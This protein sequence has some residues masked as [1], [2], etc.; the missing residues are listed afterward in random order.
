MLDIK[1]FAVFESENSFDFKGFLLK[2]A[3]Y[4]KW[5][6]ICLAITFFIAYQVNLRKQKVYNLTS[7]IA[8]KEQDNPLFTNN[9]SL[10]FNW[11]GASDQVQN[12]ASTLQSRSHNEL[13]VNK[14]NFF[15]NYLKDQKYYTEDVYGKTPF[16]I[17]LDK[18]KNQ[19]YQTPFKIIFTGTNTFKIVIETEAQSL[20]VFNYNTGQSATVPFNANQLKKNYKFGELIQLPFLNAIVVKANFPDNFV[21]EE[22]KVVFNAIDG[23]VAKYQGI[24]VEVDEK[25]S[26]V[27]RLSFTDSNKQRI[28]DFL[29]ETVNVLIQRQLDSKNLFADN[30]ISFIDTTLKRMEGEMETNNKELKDF[31]R[32]K[33]IVEL[34]SGGTELQS[35]AS[36][37]DLQ[38]EET[39]RKLQYYN[40]LT[41]YLNTSTDYSKLPA[42]TVAGIDDPNIMANVANIIALSVERSQLAYSV[43][44]PVM[45]NDIDN[46]ISSL[47]RVLLENIRSAKTAIQIQ[48]G[49]IR[50]QLGR[51]ESRLRQLPEETQ[52]YTRI[53]RK[54]DL[55]RTLYETY[56]QKRTEASIVKAANLSDIQFI[57]PAKDTGGGQIGP[58]TSANYVLAL[59]VGL[60]LP[61]LI[62]FLKFFINDTIHNLEDLNRLTNIPVLGVI[63]ISKLNT[64]LAVFESPKSALAESFRAIRSSLQFLY[65]RQ[66][67]NGSK[68]LMVTS[69]VGGEGKSF[70]AMN[71]ATVFAMSDKKT[72]VVGLDLRKPKLFD[73]FNIKNDVGVVNYL[74]GAKN[75]EDVIFKTQ[76]PN[77]DVIPSG[78]IPPNP[79]ELL[80][81][82]ALPALLDSLKEKYD[83]IILDTPPIGLVADAVE[84]V[85][86]AD[87]TLY[88]TRQNYTKRGMI[89]VLNTKVKRG[90]LNN[91]SIIFNGF[92]NK[93]KYGTYYGYDSYSYG[94]YENDT[95]DNSVISKIKS[96]LK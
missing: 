12:V 84:L 8:V 22:Y 34:E 40:L 67:V 72:V 35:Q 54:Y 56:L 68:T 89:N 15:I 47:K 38:N 28:V 2:V 58:R 10:I 43:K 24:I 61:L 93:A 91:V 59:L 73:D 49:T 30:T 18:S 44:S 83:Y 11:G 75:T 1:D 46:K 45:F 57:D 19:L 36:M 9:T 69:S 63:G 31:T 41:K 90:E 64:N 92:E 66:N 32:N 48:S 50:S 76:V 65:K 14:L 3:S 74:I 37:L 13:V 79:S 53:A 4:W 78:P 87:V 20:P 62:I 94:Y 7:T 95:K 27:L 23:T 42:P 29:N 85:H 6:L 96:K 77:L 17:E 16:K 60:L 70:C 80:M 25:S 39:N 86:H 52:D 26:S 55:N 5:F 21:N 71:I 82:D 51:T 88:V 33:N 81:S